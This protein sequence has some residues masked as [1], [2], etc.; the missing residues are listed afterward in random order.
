[1]MI[2][3]V[4]IGCGSDADDSGNA[5][6][7]DASQEATSQPEGLTDSAAS[8]T[9]ASESSASENSASENSASEESAADGTTAPDTE[10]AE[11]TPTAPLS[12]ASS[13]TASS[14][15][16]SSDASKANAV[17]PSTTE[18]TVSVVSPEEY[19]EVLKSHRGQVVLVDFWAKWCIPCIQ[20]FPHTV[21]WSKTYPREKFAAVS[22][23]FDDPESEGDVLEF[24][25]KQQATFDNLICKLGGGDE[26]FEAYEIEGGAL[27]HYKLY[28][29]TGK[30]RHTFAFSDPLAEKQFTSED[31]EQAIQELLAE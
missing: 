22:L 27:P 21:E 6:P 9:P 24:L 31:I 14:N 17:T 19:Q 4:A 1:M 5:A 29:K 7:A 23:S 20:R 13:N 18:I 11:T 3:L 25:K 10:S 30:L 2:A 8:E 28:D 16:A 15:A 12:T 26:S